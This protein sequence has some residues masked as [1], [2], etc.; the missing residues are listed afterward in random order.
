M[1]P[2]IAVILRGVTQ[3]RAHPGFVG[4]SDE[5]A[6]IE[7]AVAEARLGR[8]SVLLLGGEAGI[9]KSTLVDEGA[10]RGDVER[11]LG[12]AVP[13][14]GDAIPLAPIIDLFRQIRRT[15]PAAVTAS[16]EFAAVADWLAPAAGSSAPQAGPGATFVPVLDLL[17][18]L[19]D[20]DAFVFGIEDLQWADPATW[21]LFEFLARSL[22][23]E[24]VLLVGTYR[25]D[26]IAAD[27]TR[28][29]RL[30]DLARIA[31]V[32]QLRLGGLGRD[33]VAARAAAIIGHPAAPDVVD[34]LLARG[35]G[36][37]FFTEELLAA[38]LAGESMPAV[39]AD[40]IAAD[41]VDVDDDTRR[42]LA[43]VATL[44][45]TAR[46][47][48]LR[49]ILELDDLAVESALHDAVDRHL[50]VVDAATD[51]YGFRHA[52][53]GEVVYGELLPSERRRLHRGAADAIRKACEDG[54]VSADVAGALAFHLDRAGDPVEAFGALLAAADA[55]ATI[56]PAIALHHLERALALW[57]D[58]G[59]VAAGERRGD[60]LWQAAELAT[61]TVGNPRAAELGQ[62]A[63]R[64][65][66]PSRGEA[67]GHERL[68][69]YLWASG[70][71]E[72]S[73]VEYER[74][75]ALLAE[76]GP[77][78][79]TAP[80]RA[81]LAQAALM[82]RD[83]DGA[84]RWC[85]EVADLVDDASA[86]PVAWGTSRRVL[87]AVRSA[88]GD[89]TEG[90]RLSREA[91]AV[92]DTPHAEA[93]AMMYLCL[94]LVDLGSYEEAVSIAA[95][96]RAYVQRVGLDH[97]FGG[98]VDALAADG[99]TRL[100]RWT[101]VDELLARHV[102]R[103]PLPAGALRLGCVRAVL[104][105]RRG[106]ADQAGQ[107]L[108]EAAVPPVDRFHQAYLD[109]A[110]AEV[111]LALGDWDQAV[112]VSTRG[113]TTT[114]AGPSSGSP[115]SSGATLRPRSNRP[116]TPGP[117][118]GLSIW[119]GW[120]TACATACPSRPRPD[121]SALEADANLAHAA[122]IITRLTGP[123][124]EAWAAAAGHWEALHD[125][126][127]TAVARL[128]E[129]EA[130]V[131]TGDLARG[132][133]ALREAYE[134]ATTLGA[135]PLQSEIAALA[136]RAR[137]SLEAPVAAALDGGSVER[138]G[139]TPREA[140]VLAL[141]AAGRTNREIGAELFISEKTASVHV[142]NILRK[143]GVTSR[144]DAA[145]VAQRLGLDV[146]V[147]RRRP[148]PDASGPAARRS[149]RPDRAGGGGSARGRGRAR[150]WRR[151]GSGRCGPRC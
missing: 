142:S 132:S 136:G 97:S 26:E 94:A 78:P 6:V 148:R 77:D 56:A 143:L 30:A 72:E 118:E 46:H 2:G 39:L 15:A 34:Q 42:L 8:P 109:L 47:E 104:A 130:A 63:F 74:A 75:S 5:L 19:A 59:E 122:A 24:R 124:P 25:S 82:A 121:R 23:D 151:T 120:P 129:A 123:D 71:L 68:G 90:V 114:P 69:R 128:R 141:V 64:F 126:W 50:L 36:N 131:A 13:L 80:V 53:I 65:G 12:R 86:D 150:R 10:R 139:L 14:G 28:R 49:Q 85:E 32:R 4:R 62:L 113:A 67:W 48:L 60:R 57:D 29:R 110:A 91:V 89:P 92:A 18:R 22:V 112:E 133:T 79:T 105:A 54:P 147:D 9:G 111:H 83:L 138:L 140:E 3:G 35:E 58:V 16:P 38:H 101:D 21:D 70:R 20:D 127:L 137:L 96:A 52:L 40:L 51:D 76:V 37:P 119:W 33:D 93:L 84:E 135:A 61:G 116:S 88:R 43:V 27:P 17:A 117:R 7:T 11:H 107:W 100:G 41:L 106:H 149:G 66:P 98:Y 87:G 146:G 125:P 31:S 81:G 73:A 115:G 144:V 145:A 44:G 102:D 55:S 45:G 1:A 108:A 103:D 99:L 134:N 95:E